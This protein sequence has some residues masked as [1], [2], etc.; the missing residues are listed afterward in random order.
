MDTKFQ[1][2]DKVEMVTNVNYTTRILAI[3]ASGE[4][5]QFSQTS[6][7]IRVTFDEFG[8]TW[9]YEDEIKFVSRPTPTP[10]PLDELES[11]RAENARLKQEL[12]DL[13]Q[14]YDDLGDA[15]ELGG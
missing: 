1:V 15:Y 9:V 7:A 13:Q 3:G 11:L 14:A 5:T 2:G 8:E 12:A 4:I 10:Q 6:E